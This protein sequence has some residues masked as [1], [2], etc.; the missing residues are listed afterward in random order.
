MGRS[1][2]PTSNQQNSTTNGNDKQREHY[3]GGSYD[4]GMVKL[5]ASYQT[6]GGDTGMGGGLAAADAKMWEIGGIV[7]VGAG[8]VHVGYGMLNSD[9]AKSDAK[10]LAIAYTQNLS[11]APPRTRASTAPAMTMRFRTGL[12]VAAVSIAPAKPRPSPWVFATS[13]DRHAANRIDGAAWRP[14]SISCR[15]SS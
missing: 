14:F 1:A 7:K 3:L 12:P 15:S 10:S 2:S 6:L 5:L 9:A 8:N 4:L 11:N 13:S